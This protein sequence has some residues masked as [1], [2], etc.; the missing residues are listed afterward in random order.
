MKNCEQCGKEFE[1]QYK[2]GNEQKYCSHSCRY[3]AANIRKIEK[4]KAEYSNESRKEESKS[5]GNLERQDDRF[6]R[7]QSNSTYDIYSL[8]ERLGEAKNEAFRYQLKAEKLDEENIQLKQKIME[9]ESEI[10]EIE[11][12]DESEKGF[13]GGIPPSILGELLK[14]SAV[15]EFI[16][17]IL[18]KPSNAQTSTATR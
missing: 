9:L 1:A 17:S 5:I 12:S 2:T 16:T 13:L 8:I 18:K 14:N 6:L 11:N 4:I 3:K 15:Q 7:L 10:D